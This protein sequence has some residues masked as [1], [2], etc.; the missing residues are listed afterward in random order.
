ML[1]FL[2][3]PI[4]YSMT[5][6]AAMGALIY[7]V[8]F[9]V[10]MLESSPIGALFPG[11]VVMFYFGSVI[12]Q[13]HMSLVPCIIASVVGA[14]IGDMVS[15]YLGRYGSRFFKKE[16]K[17]LSTQNLDIGKS[18]FEKYGAK[19]IVL[20]RFI[21]PIR[22]VVPIVAGMTQ[23]KFKIFMLWNFL[24][25]LLWSV[26]YLS[27]GVVVGNHWRTVAGYFS[28]VGLFLAIVIVI[29]AIYI[30]RK[31]RKKRFGV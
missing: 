22:P 11:I 8:V 14:V 29:F 17:Y 28:E 24:G 3:E 1:E 2:I 6:F 25:A 19:S 5:Y 10:S 18:V 15:Y 27:L 31:E 23:M 7:V 4:M 30:V 26:L 21:G 13:G 9:I 20:A 12:S 16:H